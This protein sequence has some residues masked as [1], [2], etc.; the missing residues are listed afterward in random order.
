[1]PRTLARLFTAIRTFPFWFDFTVKYDVYIW[2]PTYKFTLR[3]DSLI[4][5]IVSRYFELSE[6]WVIIP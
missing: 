2:K 5:A 3:H 6:I 4:M 1:M